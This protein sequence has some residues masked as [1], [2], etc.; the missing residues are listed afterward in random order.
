MM[1]TREEVMVVA[2][3]A[4]RMSE[5]PELGITF[6]VKDKSGRQKIEQQECV[7]VFRKLLSRWNSP[8]RPVSRAQ[9]AFA[10]WAEQLGCTTL[11]FLGKSRL[12]LWALGGLAC[13]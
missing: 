2:R 1:E 7:L 5:A 10:C 9:T 11:V 6:S 12:P 3:G 8:T 4:T 13:P